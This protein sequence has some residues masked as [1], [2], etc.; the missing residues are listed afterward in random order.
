MNL[1]ID[2]YINIDTDMLRFMELYIKKEVSLTT[3]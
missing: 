2:R 3:C 1:D